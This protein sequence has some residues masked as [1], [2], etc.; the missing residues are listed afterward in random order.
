MASRTD[1][2]H[3]HIASVEILAY[4]KRALLGTAI[5]TNQNSSPG[6]AGQ[7]PT[8]IARTH[9]HE[10]RELARDHAV[11][12]L[13]LFVAARSLQDEAV[14]ALSNASPF[15]LELTNCSSRLSREARFLLVFFFLAC[16]R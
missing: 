9:P 1:N 11:P 2:F 3:L 15:S 4:G 14:A 7:D 8:R 12:D 16:V 5:R 6:G 10:K 13:L